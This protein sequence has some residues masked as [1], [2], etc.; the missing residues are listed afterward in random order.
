MKMVAE[1]Y[2]EPEP[3]FAQILKVSEI[4]PTEIY[5]KDENKDP[6]AVWDKATDRR[7]AQRQ[8]GRGQGDSPF[9]ADSIRTGSTPKWATNSLCT[10]RTSSK[11]AT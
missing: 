1:A 5:P 2:T 9:A 6:D 8:S 4:Q 10:S 7:D 3:H 11:R